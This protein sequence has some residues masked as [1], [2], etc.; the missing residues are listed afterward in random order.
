LIVNKKYQKPNIK[1]IPLKEISNFS[2]NIVLV[3]KNYQKEFEV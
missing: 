1:N 3:D 2:I